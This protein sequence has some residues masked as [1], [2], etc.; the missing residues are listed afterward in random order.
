MQ[1]GT[2]MGPRT[3]TPVLAGPVR[4]GRA[5]GGRRLAVRRSDLVAVVV[6]LFAVGYTVFA[7]AGPASRTA[8]DP[9]TRAAASAP[10]T[11]PVPDSRGQAASDGGPAAAGAGQAPSDGGPAAPVGGSGG[12]DPGATG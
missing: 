8:H 3:P 4:S 5:R 11:S 6:G 7:V 2:P 12:R 1:E 9:A 10:A